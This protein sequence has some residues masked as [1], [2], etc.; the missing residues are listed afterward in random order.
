MMREEFY[1]EM[2]EAREVMKGTRTGRLLDEATLR[3]EA[4]GLEIY[5]QQ[6][7]LAAKDQE[8]SKLREQLECLTGWLGKV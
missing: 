1:R 7:T 5:S 6:G 3:I 2:A 4:L 8:I